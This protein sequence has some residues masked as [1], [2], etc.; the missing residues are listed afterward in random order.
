MY[1]ATIQIRIN[2]FAP[3]TSGQIGATLSPPNNTSA[4]GTGGRN[5]FSGSGQNILVDVPPTYVG[6]VQLV[7]QLPDPNYVLLGI[8]VDPTAAPDGTS[9]GRQEFRT[10]TINRDPSGSQLT[11]TDAC[12]R[13]FG[14]IDFQ[15]VILVQQ[16][17]SGAIGIIDPGIDDEPGE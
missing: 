2:S 1:S 5:V 14:N 16:V 7:F 13:E 17:S 4:P 3:I 8:S 9:V 12:N 15:Y 6:A 10:I 11:V